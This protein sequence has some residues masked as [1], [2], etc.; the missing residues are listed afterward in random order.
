[1]RWCVPAIASTSPTFPG[2]KVGKHSTGGVGDKIS[3]VLAPVAASC[4]V[5]VPKMSGRGLGHTGGTLDKLES[6][7]GFRI[8]LTIEEFKQALR[9]VGTAIIGQTASLAPADK[10]LYALR[11]VTATVESIPLISASIMS[12]KL[13]EGSNALVLDVKCGDGAFM[14]DPERA[15]ML[16]VSMVAIGHHAGV[17]TEAVITD[18]EAPLGRA[19]GNALEIIECLDTLKGAGPAGADG[20]WFTHLASRMVLLAG[21]ERSRGGATARVAAALASGRALDTFARMIERQGGNPRVVDDYSLLPSAPD[22]DDLPRAARRLSDG[23]QGRSGRPCEQRARRGPKQGRRRR[24]SRRRCGG[25]APSRATAW[26]PGSRCSN[27]T[28]ATAAAS[29]R[30]WPSAATRRAIGDATA[31]T[32]EHGAGRSAV[33]EEME[34]CGPIMRRLRATPVVDEPRS[35]CVL[36]GLAAIAAVGIALGFAGATRVQPVAGLA[37]ILALAYCLS[38]A[39]RVDRLSHR[40]VGSR[41]AIPVRPHRPQDRLWG[42]RSSRQLGSV[43]TQPPWLCLRRLVV[44][45]RAARQPSG[46]AE[47]HDRRARARAADQYANIFAFMVLPTIIFIAALFAML[48]YFGV[49]QIIVRLFAVIMRRFMRASGAESLNVAASIFMGQTEAPLTIRPF[50]PRMTESELMTV[51]TVGHGAHLRRRDGGL[52]PVWRRGATPA[53]GG[54]HDRA[55]H[56]DDG[57]AVRPGNGR[58]GNDGD[59][60]A[61]ASRPLT[62]T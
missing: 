9:D 45:V 29:R 13:A 30:P 1:M 7:P 36:G 34:L 27:C 20:S 17:R 31:A 22:R 43:I 39:R 49:M 5:V 11:D 15:R 54:H 50:L 33:S 18:M 46:V 37:L 26:P 40:G 53:D 21:S 60:E 8:D 24:R 48:Y 52:H 42:A 44:R 32:P 47:H 10:K 16:A 14:K 59:G 25:A 56:V 58:A 38:S 35:S 3:I 62:S 61:A 41:A 23:T 2:V 57:Q 19:V 51:M 12:K 6:I 55:R 4:G 28:T